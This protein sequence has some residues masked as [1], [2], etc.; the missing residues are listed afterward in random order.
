MIFLVTFLCVLFSLGL[1]TLF[2]TSPAVSR[3]EANA[4]KNKQFAHRGLWDEDIPENSL[5]AFAVAKAEGYGVELD[6]RLTADGEVVVFHDGSLQRMCGVNEK[7]CE[8]TLEEL[9]KHRLKCTDERIP[10]LSEA[11]EA[12]GGA[13]L[14]C[15]IKDEGARTAQLCEKT[16]NILRTYGGKYCVESFSPF[17]VR[18]FYKHRPHIVRGQ[19]AQKGKGCLKH[20]LAGWLCFNF[21]GRPDFIAY[22]IARHYPPTLY[23]MR[24]LGTPVIAWTVRSEEDLMHAERVFDSFIF[25][26]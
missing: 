7:V 3:P 20:I 2:L 15:E 16:A 11:L 9:K 6:V 26:E 21:M 23:L 1:L 24:L 25:E 5:A 18:W 8:L 17:A 12:L 13:E 4:L 22:G 19:L 14:I 10:T